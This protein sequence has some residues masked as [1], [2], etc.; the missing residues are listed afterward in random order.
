MRRRPTNA[1]CGPL[2]LDLLLI[3]LPQGL[4]DCSTHAPSRLTL[5]SEALRIHSVSCLAVLA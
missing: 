5:S 4:A 1:C 3:V 2:V